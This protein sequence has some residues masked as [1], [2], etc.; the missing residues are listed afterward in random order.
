MSNK[1]SALTE[2]TYPIVTSDEVY[3]IRGGQEYKADFTKI[4]QAFF[5]MVPGYEGYIII[6]ASGNV[7]AAIVEQ[8]D[9]LIGKGAYFS[10]E[11]V[12]MRAVQ[13]SPTLNTHFKLGYKA[14]EQP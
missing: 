3:I 11:Y 14:E 6:P 1:L 7:N 8:N 5:K 4:G 10:G 9:I 12:M 2:I 13:D